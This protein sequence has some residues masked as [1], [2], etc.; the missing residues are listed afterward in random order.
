M[1]LFLYRLSLGRWNR[2]RQ[3]CLRSMLWKISSTFIKFNIKYLWLF[4]IKLCNYRGR[5]NEIHGSIYQALSRWQLMSVRSMLSAPHSWNNSDR[6][7]KA[8][9]N[10]NRIDHKNKSQTK[11]N[12]RKHRKITEKS[13]KGRKNL[14]AVFDFFGVEGSFEEAIC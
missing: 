2:Y 14:H 12:N 13:L 7:E 1:C 11:K 9:K 6:A 4:V 10:H 3:M 8:N 5:S